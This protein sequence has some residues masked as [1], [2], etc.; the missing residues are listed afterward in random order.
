[1]QVLI[2]R[3]ASR[4]F[5]RLA[6]L[7]A[8]TAL[9]GCMSFSTVQTARTMAPGQVQIMA[10]AGTVGASTQTRDVTT[11]AGGNTVTG[12]LTTET[13]AI[14]EIELGARL[15]LTPGVDVG[16]KLS[17][18]FNLMG[19]VKAQFIDSGG[20]A[21]AAG[22]GLGYQEFGINDDT[23]TTVDFVVPLYFSY[24]ATDWL[25]L[26]ASPKYFLRH[27]STNSATENLH[28]AGATGGIKLGSR[29]GIY[30]E[31]TEL[32]VLNES[33]S[34][35][36]TLG[37]S[38]FHLAFFFDFGDPSPRPPAAPMGPQP[39]Y[40]DAPTPQEPSDG[41]PPAGATPAPAPPPQS[42]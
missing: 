12:P 7:A 27:M 40:Q 11:D 36:A 31:A 5:I 26:Y 29:F 35:D 38:Q 17:L 41:P 34:S 28:L 42:R 16:V 14:P 30:L 33:K 8:A 13:V 9:P 20:F 23:F 22:L 2:A 18:P 39:P 32:V 10:G 4:A 37:F 19:D 25:T 3:D 24:D 6:L 1:M 15:G 21:A